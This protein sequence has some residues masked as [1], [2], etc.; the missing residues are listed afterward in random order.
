MNKIAVRNAANIAVSMILFIMY[1]SM[2]GQNSIERFLEK[3]IIITEHE[4]KPSSMPPPGKESLLLKPMRIK[5]NNS[6]NR[7]ISSQ[8]K[9]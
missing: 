5:Y 3:K 8:Y 9:H 2:F 4:E 1:V 7:N 6:S